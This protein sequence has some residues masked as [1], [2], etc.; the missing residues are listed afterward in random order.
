MALKP[1]QVL[2]LST[3]DIFIGGSIQTYADDGVMTD[4]KMDVEKLRPLLFEMAR[5]KYWRLGPA[6]G[7]YFF[8]VSSTILNLSAC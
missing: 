2:D 1:Y 3:H 8:K 7:N 4:G 6:V 5:K